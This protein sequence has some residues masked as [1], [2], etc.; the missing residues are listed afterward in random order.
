MYLEQIPNHR[1]SEFISLIQGDR[2]I[3][4]YGTHKDDSDETIHNL[5]IS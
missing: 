5:I 3:V 2:R 4:A 1:I